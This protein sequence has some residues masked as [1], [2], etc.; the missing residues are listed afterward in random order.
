MI[1]AVVEDA[2]VKRDIFRRADEVLPAAGDARLEH[3]VDPD[4]ARSPLRRRGPTA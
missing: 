4:H 1:E 2:D 3:V